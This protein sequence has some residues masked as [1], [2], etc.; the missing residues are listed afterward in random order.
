[1]FD[2]FKMIKKKEIKSYKILIKHLEDE[3]EAAKGELEYHRE[4][5][6]KLENKLEESEE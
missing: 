1:M 2:D 4:E 6:K 3:L 5:L